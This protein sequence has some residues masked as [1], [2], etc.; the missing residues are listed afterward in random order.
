MFCGAF[1]IL[2]GEED[3]ALGDATEGLLVWGFTVSFGCEDFIGTDLYNGGI[4]MG[5]LPYEGW[6]LSS[7]LNIVTNLAYLVWSEFCVKV[8]LLFAWL[9]SRVCLLCGRWL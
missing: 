9:C 1:G 3:V 2:D 7:K 4:L 8:G 5:S 6:V